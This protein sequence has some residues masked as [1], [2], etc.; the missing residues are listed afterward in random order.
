MSKKSNVYLLKVS[1]DD[2]YKIGVAKDV[3]RRVRQLQ[4]G[5]PEDIKI[6]KVFP[7]DY[8]FK[9]ESVLHRKHKFNQV[10]GECFYLSPKDID[11]FINTCSICE[12]SFKILD[13]SG[14]PFF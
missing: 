13:E 11:D 5:N 12:N 3:N 6:I 7:T 8:P 14:N 2:I 4:T 1:S 10:K 9:L